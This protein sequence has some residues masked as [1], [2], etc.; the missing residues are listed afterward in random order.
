MS[1]HRRRTVL[2]RLVS[3]GLLALAGCS[4]S[5]GTTDLTIRNC[6]DRSVEVS[7]TVTAENGESV[8]DDTHAVQAETC[9][10]ATEA[11]VAVDDVVTRAGTYT[12]TAAAPEMETVEATRS[13][14][15]AVV[16]ND[17]DAFTVYVEESGLSVN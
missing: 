5:T 10:G 14:G 9:S 3:I 4:V 7:V 17:D 15:E 6:L 12:V 1:R 13:F 11:P 2:R 8:Y 16:E